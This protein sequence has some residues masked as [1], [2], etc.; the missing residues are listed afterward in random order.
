MS[1]TTAYDGELVGE[2]CGRPFG[3][4]QLVSR[5]YQ[6]GEVAREMFINLRKNYPAWLI[7]TKYGK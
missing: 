7:K 2:K 1:R 4:N 3:K 5:G 6:L